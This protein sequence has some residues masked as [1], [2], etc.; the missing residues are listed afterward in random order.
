MRVPRRI[1]EDAPW[2]RDPALC[3]ARAMIL[4]AAPTD[5][6][7]LIHGE[8][9]SGKERAAR[10]A[11]DASAR[12]QERFVALNCGAL[13]DPLI[14]SELF[15][16]ARGAFTGA[17][18]PRA[19]LFEAA[20]GGT[21]FLDEVGDASPL[22][23][24][25]LLRALAEGGYRRLGETDERRSDV[26]IVAATHREL[27][28]EVR[29]QRFRS[30]LGYRLAAIEVFP[31]PLR[32]RGGDILWLAGRFLAARAPHAAFDVA[33]RRAL[34]GY[35]WPGNVRELEWAVARAALFVEPDGRVPWAALPERVRAGA[36]AGG[37]TVAAGPA[38]GRAGG[39]ALARALAALEERWIRDALDRSGGRVAGAARTL[40]LSRQ[41]LWN[42]LKRIERREEA[43]RRRS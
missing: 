28:E 35:A 7:I 8:T 37:E 42:K 30:D 9:G 43:W 36:G 19:G 29:A 10:A 17:L 20:R 5:L 27:E 23:Q 12:A 34:R 31:P 39:A 13:P 2:G 38:E 21:L 24:I 25:K 32:A 18:G 26:R 11:H 15:G 41:G 40:G 22:L 1:L 3:A 6:P 4:R 16:H 33:A 14:E